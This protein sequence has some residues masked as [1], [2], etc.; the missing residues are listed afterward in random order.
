[1]LAFNVHLDGDPSSMVPSLLEL[2]AYDQRPVGLR[3]IDDIVRL[4][5]MRAIDDKSIRCEQA[6]DPAT[7]T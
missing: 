4:G 5:D 1:V 2:T 3:L 7:L 6:L